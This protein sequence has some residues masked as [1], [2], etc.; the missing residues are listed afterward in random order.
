[1]TTASRGLERLYA[2]RPEVEG[3]CGMLVSPSVEV[4]ERCT[5][6]LEYAC[7]ELASCRTWADGAH[8]NPEALVEAHCL[9][10]AVRRACRLLESAWDYYTKW[11]QMWAALSAG[12]TA[13]GEPPA[14]ARRGMLFLTG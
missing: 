6:V 7:S 14:T 4:L 9:Q 12:Y 3:V 2:V 13:R 5:R 8:G 11:N 1:M 10:D